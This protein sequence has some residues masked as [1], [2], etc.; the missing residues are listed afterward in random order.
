M[1]SMDYQPGH[2]NPIIGFVISAATFV[3]GM[4][5]PS[6]D[7]SPGVVHLFQCGAFSAAMITGLITTLN[8]FEIKWNPFKKK[9]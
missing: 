1:K 3:A 5:A 8:Y 4:S 6:W 9:K 7:I 2:S